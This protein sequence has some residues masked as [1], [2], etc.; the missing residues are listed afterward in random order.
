MSQKRSFV[1]LNVPMNPVHIT[2][3][4]VVRPGDQSIWKECPVTSTLTEIFTG[5]ACLSSSFLALWSC[6]ASSGASQAVP[7]VKNPP[8]NAGDARDAISIPGLGRFPGGGHGNPFQYS[9]LE[10]PMDRGAWWATVH[11]V[12]KSRSMHAIH[13]SSEA[14]CNGLNHIP[15][16]PPNSYVEILPPSILE[17]DYIWRWGF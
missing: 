14:C 7:V 10:N 11:G 16:P 12:T 17:C 3:G 6:I 9:C 4:L 13:A 5:Y 8:A 2:L 1:L 15:L